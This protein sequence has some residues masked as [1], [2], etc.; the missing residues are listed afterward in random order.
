MQLWKHDPEFTHGNASLR[1][2]SEL[3]PCA[4]LHHSPAQADVHG[5]LRVIG[6]IGEDE[7]KPRE[8]QS[9]LEAFD[10]QL[11]AIVP[12]RVGERLRRTI[13]AGQACAFEEPGETVPRSVDR[14]DES[15]A[16]P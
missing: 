14:D 9:V 1:R 13:D 5:P 15:F 6:D 8:L 2:K 11:F 3:D 16:Q 12:N 4:R 10:R 7:L